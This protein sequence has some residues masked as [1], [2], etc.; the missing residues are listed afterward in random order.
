[1]PPQNFTD[2]IYREYPRLRGLGFEI[3]DSRN[4]GLLNPRNRG[5]GRLEFYPPDERDN[6][7]QGKPTIEIFDPYLGGKH[8]EQAVFGDMLHY[9]P[10]V[11]PAFAHLRDEFAGTLT[12]E[13]KSV[14]EDAYSRGVIRADLDEPHGERRTFEDWF[15]RSRLAAYI[16][17]YLAPDERDEWRDVY[18]EKQKK[19][20]DR[21]EALLRKPRTSV[22]D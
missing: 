11:D 6:P 1:M 19:L 18:T 12:D 5:G 13:Q 17:G 4:I 3:L 20:L 15:N 8:L 7:V 10:E 9:M 16:R 22:L 21:M 2:S 14:D